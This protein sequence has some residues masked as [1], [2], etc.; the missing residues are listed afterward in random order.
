M[1]H[2]VSIVL[3]IPHTSIIV[4][5]EVRQTILLSDNELQQELLRMTDAFTDELFTRNTAMVHQIV[6]PVSRLVIDPERFVDDSH[7]PL[8]KQGMGVVYTRTSE[9]KRLRDHLTDAEREQLISM[10]YLPHHKRLQEA[11]KQQLDEHNCC[12]ILDCHS[13]PPFPLPDQ[14][15][16]VFLDQDLQTVTHALEKLTAKQ[17]PTAKTK[18][19]GGKK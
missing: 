12:L 11:V 5:P 9:G 7:E 16:S 14:F 13:F 18:I 4:P 2:P 8:A 3:N 1:S 6:F 10:Y 17:R 15:F 19:R